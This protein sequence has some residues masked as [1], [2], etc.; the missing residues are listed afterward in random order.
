MPTY[1][2]RRAV[3]LRDAVDRDAV[4]RGSTR[5]ARSRCRRNRYR[6]PCTTPDR[7]RTRDST[8]RLLVTRCRPSPRTSRSPSV[9]AERSPD[10]ST[11]ATV[12]QVPRAVSV[13]LARSRSS[14]DSAS[15]ASC[16]PTWS[17]SASPAATRWDVEK[18][19]GLPSAP[20]PGRTTDPSSGVAPEVIDHFAPLA[21]VSTCQRGARRTRPGIEFVQHPGDEWVRAG[22]PHR[23]D[24]PVEDRSDLLHALTRGEIPESSLLV[25]CEWHRHDAIPLGRIEYG[26]VHRC[27]ATAWLSPDLEN[28]PFGRERCGPDRP[29]TP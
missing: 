21:D 29:I 14:A 22:P 24:R 13:S 9:S 1:R 19:R 4:G 11:S 23:L 7:A 3:F 5:P 27:S 26:R 12:V 18:A 8:A 20:V 2:R 16:F 17:R 6:A 10:V 25:V 28:Q 15:S